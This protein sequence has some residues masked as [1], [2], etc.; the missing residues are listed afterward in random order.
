MSVARICQLLGLAGFANSTRCR[1][2]GVVEWCTT[3]SYAAYV[4]CGLDEFVDDVGDL[5]GHP[6]TLTGVT[7]V[8]KRISVGWSLGRL[9]SLGVGQAPPRGCGVPQ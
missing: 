5:R 4:R 2:A 9:P 6:A 1:G 3:P 8:H 7:R